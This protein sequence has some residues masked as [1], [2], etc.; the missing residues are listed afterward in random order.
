MDSVAAVDSAVSEV[1]AAAV[2]TP[3]AAAL[4]AA[5][6]HISTVIKL[7]QML[8]TIVGS[9]CSTLHSVLPQSTV[10]STDSVIALGRCIV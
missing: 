8:P 7:K 1:A 2:A 10:Y 6:K 4:P 9:I 5:G 3:A